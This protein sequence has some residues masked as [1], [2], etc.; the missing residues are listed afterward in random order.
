MTEDGKVVINTELNT[1]GVKKG[2]DGLSKDIKNN[3]SAQKLNIASLT[4]MGTAIGA[5]A[6]ATKI[7]AKTVKE[8]TDA[9]KT[10]TKAEVQLET[11][12]KNNP[13]LNGESVQNLKN[14]ADELSRISTISGGELTGNMANLAATGRTQA[15]IQEIMSAALDL[16][17]SGMMSFESAVDTLNGTLNGSAGALG[18]Q[19]GAL[20]DLTEEEL[21]QGKAIEIVKKNY[22]GMSEEL[23]KSVGSSERLKNAFSD[24]KSNIGEPFE[25][26]MSPMRNFFA[27]LINGW[28]DAWKSKKRY[29]EVQDI[30]ANDKQGKSSGTIEEQLVEEIKLLAEYQLEYEDAVKTEGFDNSRDIKK[31]QD[32]VQA[33]L[34]LIAGLEEE[35][36]AYIELEQAQKRETEA[37]QKADELAKQQAED[38]QKAAAAKLKYLETVQ[39]AE[40]EI[41]WRRKLGEEISE[42]EKAQQMLNVRMN[43]YLQMLEDAEGTI[44][45][46][47]GFALTERESINALAQSLK[48]VADPNQGQKDIVNSWYKEQQ[49]SLQAQKEQIMMYREYLAERQDLT[50]E[51]IE[52]RNKLADAIINIDKAIVEE[53]KAQAEQTKQANLKKLDDITEY[54]DRFTEITQGMTDIAQRN[55]EQQTQSELTELSKQYTDG[56]ISYQEYCDKKEQ[57]SKDAAR[58][59]YQLDM[60]NWSASLL[61]ATANVA[62]GVAKAIAEGGVAGIITGSLVAAAGAV[63]IASITANKPRPVG[64]EHGGIIGGNSYTGD[65]VPIMANS[66]EGVFTLQQQKRLFDIANGKSGGNS[67]TV[68]VI[69]NRANDTSVNQRL[70]GNTLKVTID[71]I[72]AS[73]MESGRYNNSL[74]I[75]QN[76]AGGTTYL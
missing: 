23:A 75:Q 27:D 54:I 38:D 52:M 9:Y 36:Q 13:F 57:I 15:Q 70:D 8:C 44:S 53:E 2:L 26:A 42:E 25:K 32:K 48:E 7:A 14:Y 74:A 43:A 18:K 47:K 6:A 41:E 28:N 50:D 10:Q 3:T 64:F 30:N 29:E 22:A 65:H 73:S 16:S 39:K 56:L 24:L 49:L 76:N 46:N 4:K 62:Q 35:K 12:A 58:K 60:W 34:N 72:V 20:K 66:R 21:K 55:N 33:Q 19:I 37:Q 71:K 11:A 63:Q 45:G 69:N 40:E 5:V 68:Q 51:E 61:Q 67:M 17:A 59:Q 1:E 31:W